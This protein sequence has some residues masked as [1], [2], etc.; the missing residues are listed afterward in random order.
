MP[1]TFHENSVDLELDSPI[2]THEKCQKCQDVLYI[3][4]ID[5]NYEGAVSTYGHD[6][7]CTLACFKSKK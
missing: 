6:S 5:P 7:Y 1:F 2:I 4:E 3:D